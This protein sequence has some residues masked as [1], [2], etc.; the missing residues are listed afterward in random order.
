[1]S[2]NRS[3]FVICLIPKRTT[4]ASYPL[5]IPGNALL[6]P[7]PGSHRPYPTSLTKPQTRNYTVFP[8][9]KVNYLDK[10]IPLVLS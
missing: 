4:N 8:I 1:M 10:E 7:S 2:S 9:P 5:S 3:V 6:P